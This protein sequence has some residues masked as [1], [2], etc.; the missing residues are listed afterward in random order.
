[1]RFLKSKRSLGLCSFVAVIAVGSAVAFALTFAQDDYNAFTAA[2]RAATTGGQ[3]SHGVGALNLANSTTTIYDVE[4]NAIKTYTDSVINCTDQRLFAYTDSGGVTHHYWGTWEPSAYGLIS[5]TALQPGQISENLD[6]RGFW[7]NGSTKE[8]NGRGSPGALSSA[9]QI[10]SYNMYGQGYKSSTGAYIT[11]APYTNATTGNNDH[12]IMM[13]SFVTDRFGAVN[14]GGG[15]VHCVVP[16]IDGYTGAATF[17][18]DNFYYCT[19]VA[20][21]TTNTFDTSLNVNGS[22]TA[23]YGKFVTKMGSLYG[24]VIWQH[25]DPNGTVFVHHT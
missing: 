2:Q 4:L 20:A 21:I 16:A 23:R 1:M 7:M 9:Y 13:W 25:T 3:P 22:V 17:G 15:T 5:V 11:F 10:K 18:T 24:W 19:D 8:R 14:K 6:D 12:V